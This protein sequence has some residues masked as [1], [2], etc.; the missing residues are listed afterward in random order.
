MEDRHGG[1]QGIIVFDELEKTKSHLLISQAQ[2]YF[3]ESATGLH[4][5]SRIVPE[6]FFVH[7][8]LTT[9]VQIA[10]L[11]AY[12]ISWGFR[13]QALTRPARKELEP[14]AKLVGSLR[15][16][17]V[18]ERHGNS[19]FQIWSFAHVRDLRTRLEKEERQ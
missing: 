11:V 7:S 9:G 13:F 3:R 18:R 10:D 16:V 17:A 14:F 15:S 8:D 6:P 12:T 19:Q 1:E 5:S 2:K 4:R